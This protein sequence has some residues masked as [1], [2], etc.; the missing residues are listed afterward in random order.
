M[1]GLGLSP[2]DPS[3]FARPEEAAVS[4]VDLY[5]DVDFDHKV[6]SGR[7]DLTVDK[8][9]DDVT[10]VILDSKD[11]NI[12]RIIDH[13]SQQDLEFTVGEKTETLGSK[14]E[15]K[16]PS[17]KEDRFIISIFYETDV[18]ASALQWLPPEQTA[19]GKHPYLFSQC[20]AVHC[21]S[22]F[23]CQDTPSVKVT[24]NAEITAPTELTVLMSARRVGAPTVASARLKLHKFEQPIPI[25][26]YLVAIVVGFLESRKLGPRSHVW[27]EVQDVDKA[28]YEFAE[29]ED[30]LS[31][32]ES[33]CGEYIWGIYDLLV[34]PPSFP[35]GGMENPCITFVT[36]TVLAGDRSLADVVAHEISHSWT[37]NLVTNRNFEHFWLNE[38]FTV[39]LE[40]KILAKLYGEKTRQF[41]AIG[42]LK[43]LKD[44][45]AA[46]GE[47]SPLTCLVPDLKGISPDDAFS[48][49]PYEKGHTLLFHLEELAGGPEV[50][51]PF[52]KAYINKFK[53]RSIDTD[54][55]IKFLYEYFPNNSKLKEVDWKKWL[56]TPGMPP[57]I[58]KY[59]SSLE[60]VC[61]N[62]CNK[63]LDWDAESTCPFSPENIKGL[64]S[65]Q[66]QEFLTQLLEKKPLSVTKLQVMENTYKFSSVVNSEIRFRWLRLVIKGRWLEQV[67]HALEFVVEQGR[68][69]FVRP[70]YRDLYDWEEVR[71]RAIAVY[72]SN[73]S[74][75]MYVAAYGVAKD[76]HL[77]P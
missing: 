34:L 3:S 2:G 10:H 55:F 28:A 11:L 70:L 20:Q 16:L 14:L 30:M 31:A 67:A 13:V 72:E 7:A 19:G 25:P 6:L 77:E 8:K 48:R 43:D 65:S 66:V 5:L 18:N 40:R 59:D 69:K 26:V 57:V 46:I 71:D 49:V 74:R 53:Y 68:M 27:S 44:A 12:E 58:P 4:S 15:I 54:D 63:W 24:Y 9:K 23:P 50:F 52:L 21:R 47:N 45:I 37:G 75:M 35:F 38:G 17:T 51:D 29:T 22:M 64:S 62:L 56:F 36:P 32:A 42:G 1:A 73:K 76:L 33:I 39:F 60:E 41:S 61:T